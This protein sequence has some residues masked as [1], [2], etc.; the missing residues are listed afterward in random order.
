MIAA[1]LMTWS[2]AAPRMSAANSAAVQSKNAKS[3]AASKHSSSTLSAPLNNLAKNGLDGCHVY[4]VK[5]LPG[6]REYA[7]EFLETMAT[8]FGG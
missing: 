8:K 1:A 7:S 5:T 4:K 2:V 3:K 6:S